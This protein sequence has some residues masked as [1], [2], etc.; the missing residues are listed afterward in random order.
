M[1]RAGENEPFGFRDDEG[2]MQLFQELLTSSG[3]F[4]SD[5][6]ASRVVVGVCELPL[7]LLLFSNASLLLPLLQHQ[8]FHVHV[9]Y[10]YVLYLYVWLMFIHEA[11]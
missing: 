4:M 2:S 1:Y 7:S 11:W 3:A 9:I 6:G 5:R 8:G 10:S